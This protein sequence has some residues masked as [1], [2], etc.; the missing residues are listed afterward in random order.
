MFYNDLFIVLDFPDH[1]KLNSNFHDFSGPETLLP[2]GK[3]GVL[4]LLKMYIY[5]K[6]PKTFGK[7]YDYIAGFYVRSFL[8]P[9][10]CLPG[11]AVRG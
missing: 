5:S 7:N 11:P 4:Y 1:V 6:R 8:S 2:I 10:H 9:N 3:L